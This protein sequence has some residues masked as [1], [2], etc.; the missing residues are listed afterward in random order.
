MDWSTMLYDAVLLLPV[1]TTTIFASDRDIFVLVADELH[2]I[3]LGTVLN[4]GTGALESGALVKPDWNWAAY[5]D[6]GFTF[7]GR[8]SEQSLTSNYSIGWAT[9]DALALVGPDCRES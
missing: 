1:H 5:A 6:A 7:T 4:P 9:H 8:R 3:K 2:P